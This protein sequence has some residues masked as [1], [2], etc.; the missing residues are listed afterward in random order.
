MP[1][2][3]TQQPGLPPTSCTGPLQQL[4][5]NRCGPSEL[6]CT[7]TTLTV[8][9]SFSTMTGPEFGVHGLFTG[10]LLQDDLRQLIRGFVQMWRQ[11]GMGDAT[12]A[13]LIVMACVMSNGPLCSSQIDKWVSNHSVVV[14]AR[15]RDMSPHLRDFAVPT[16]ELSIGD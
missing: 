1:I 6:V 8:T 10:N 5:S 12:T 16:C 11:H 7:T 13:E 3:V 2:H 4:K 14:S 9:M 15:P